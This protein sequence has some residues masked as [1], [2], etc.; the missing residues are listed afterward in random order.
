MKKLSSNQLI[1][2]RG[3][4]LVGER[5]LAMGLSFDGRNRLETGIDGF[6]ELRDPLTGQMLA[7]WIG[8][9]VKTTASGQYSYE[10]EQG[11]EYLLAADDLEY[12]SGTNI[13]V[14]IVLVRLDIGD[15]YWKAVHDGNYDEPRRLK[16]D[17]AK[18]QFNREAVDSIA[19]LCI[20]RDR[21][22]SYVPP[23]RSGENVHLNMLR[24][25]LP[26]NIFVGASLYGSGREAVRELV[27][28]DAHPP[29]DWVIR[30]RRFISFKD[31]R[32]GPLTEIVDGGSI[33]V[34][35]TESVSLTDDVD[36][37]RTFIDLLGR[38]LSAQLDENLSFDRDSHALFF[39]A[40]AQN[41]GRKYRYQS[42]VNETSADVVFVWHRKKDGQI[43]SVR[44]HA[45]IPRFQRIG[46]EWFV[47]VTP[48]FVFT[49]DG[50]RPHYNAS[51]LLA[52]KKKMEK[53]GAIR[54]QFIMWRHLLINSENVEDDLLSAHEVR[55]VRNL[56]FE[57][58]AP[59]EMPLAVPEE[60]W[61]RE[62]P[63][64]DNM[65]DAEGLL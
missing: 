10:D 47:S 29:F 34:V 25:V 22:G 32:G 1:G 56:K 5:T 20:E 19:A 62:D 53:N 51:A 27:K 9:Q 46:D 48:T 50:F 8:A 35:E 59:I 23:M 44:H 18:D 28:V 15:M 45:F 38:T 6:L 16:F 2:Q 3:E 33:E 36:D 57:A 31:P 37:E 30:D 41:K 65:I 54:G 60:S 17:K 4:L 55:R 12:W 7:K 52:G 24:I 11:F 49:H 42:L 58:L 61:R 13:P 43:G 64:A 26:K 40:R 63:N 14:I 21:L 39:R